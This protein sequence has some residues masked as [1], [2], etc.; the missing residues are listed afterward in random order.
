MVQTQ[1]DLEL[2][3]SHVPHKATEDCQVSWVSFGPCLQMSQLIEMR[4]PETLFQRLSGRGV[5]HPDA[6]TSTK[7][8]PARSARTAPLTQLIPA[9]R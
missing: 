5:Q 6:P 8:V 4:K 9:K 7:G 3:C 1:C 2:Q